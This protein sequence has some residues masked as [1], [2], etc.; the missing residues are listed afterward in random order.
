MWWEG[1]G[2]GP[3]GF[4]GLEVFWLLVFT[5]SSDR[6]LGWSLH[7]GFGF[8]PQGEGPTIMGLAGCVEVSWA[9]PMSFF[10]VPRKLRILESL[11]GL[12]SAVVFRLVG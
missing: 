5:N 1:A 7:P 6:V 4:H 9:G 2:F 3:Q 11:L 8:R 12:S 10:C